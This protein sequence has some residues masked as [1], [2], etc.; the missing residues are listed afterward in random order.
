MKGEETLAEIQIVQKQK[1]YA[2]DI[3]TTDLNVEL[4][5]FKVLMK[6]K[7]IEHF[8]DLLKEMRL[9]EK[10]EKKYLTNICKYWQ[11]TQHIVQQ[12]K[13]PFLWREE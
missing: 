1:N 10:P 5:T 6:G 13:E 2:S 3:N 12:L 7:E 4:A 8:H 9:L 11:L